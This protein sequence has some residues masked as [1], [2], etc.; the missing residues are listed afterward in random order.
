[1]FK[2]ICSSWLSS[3]KWIAVDEEFLFDIRIL[4]A[5]PRR[6]SGVM[7]LTGTECAPTRAK[8]SMIDGSRGD[9]KR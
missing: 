8:T 6:S 3:T 4:I 9:E 5:Q 1:M 7:S 2:I